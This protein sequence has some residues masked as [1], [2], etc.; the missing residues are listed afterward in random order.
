VRPSKGS[1]EFMGRRLPARAHEV[2]REG[3]ALVPEGRR[4]F[5]NLT[6]YQNLIMGAYL[7]RDLAEMQKDKERVYGLFPRLKE[8]ERQQASTLSGGEQQMLAIGRALMS[9]PKMLLL[10][11]PSLGLA[12]ILVRDI[13]ATLKEINEEGT[14]VLLVEQNARQALKLAG[15]A[16]VFQTGNVVLSGRSDDLL[17]DRQVQEAYLGAGGNARRRPTARPAVTEG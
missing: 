14:T 4:V 15:R 9:R 17:A 13:F 10:D 2:V 16:Y 7:R 6:V 11:E 12:P 5:G 8:R 1:V 3:I